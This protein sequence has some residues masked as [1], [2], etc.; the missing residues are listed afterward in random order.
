MTTE[1][2][3]EVILGLVEKSP[4]AALLV[5]LIFLFTQR[6][7]LASW[8]GTALKEPVKEGCK[9]ALREHELERFLSTVP[10]NGAPP[11]PAPKEPHK[12]EQM[13]Q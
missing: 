12:S 3:I 5:L 8:L 1:K 7:V 4:L 9:E 6:N 11:A 2:L 13:K 10:S